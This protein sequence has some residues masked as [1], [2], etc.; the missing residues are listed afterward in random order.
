[1][2]YDRKQKKYLEENEYKKDTLNFL[3]NTILQL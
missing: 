3:Y 1:M 2:Y